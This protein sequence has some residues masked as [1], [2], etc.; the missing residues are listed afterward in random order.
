MLSVIP[1]AT[2]SSDLDPKNTGMGNVLFQMSFT[3]AISQ[4]YE[5]CEDYSFLGN[6]LEKLDGY[7]LNHRETIYRNIDTSSKNIKYKCKLSERKGF[8]QMYDQKLLEKIKNNKKETILIEGSYLQS[9]MYFDHYRDDIQKLFEPDESS[10]KYISK[11]YPD[12]ME[13]KNKVSIHLRLKWGGGI[14]YKSD[15]LVNIL[16][17][18][19]KDS[20]Y[21]IFSDDIP[22]AKKILKGLVKNAVYCD[23]N[24]DYIDMWMMSL[25]K[26]NILCHS[27]LGW[28]GAYLNKNEDKKIYYPVEVLRLKRGNLNENIVADER[29]SQFFMEDWLP[30]KGTSIYKK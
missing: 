11:K 25:C 20:K 2:A 23:N 28:W 5:M 26:Y 22:E 12:F 8:S 16:S 21:Y 10:I 24:P 1:T 30:V 14:S 13:R 6:L 4:K 3:Y 9:H 27:T 17:D 19:D 29:K 18:L 7:G 15:Y